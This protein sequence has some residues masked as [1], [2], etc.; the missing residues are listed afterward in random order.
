MSD[1]KLSWKPYASYKI[2]LILLG[3][4]NVIM[5]LLCIHILMIH[6]YFP[7][8]IVCAAVFVLSFLLGIRL[9]QYYPLQVE[10]TEN[11]ITMKNLRTKETYESSLRDF[12]AVY[13]L[14]DHNHCKLILFSKQILS[15]EK[16]KQFIHHFFHHKTL[17]L[18][19][20]GNLCIVFTS[21]KGDEIIKAA[22]KYVPVYDQRNGPRI[23]FW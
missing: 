6:Q 2:V 20:D 22:Q 5:L 17:K 16:Q 1:F 19:L 10:M 8:L 11:R 4:M 3:L 21:G 13:V 12:Q 14:A 23:W 15:F 18:S 7:V 9:F